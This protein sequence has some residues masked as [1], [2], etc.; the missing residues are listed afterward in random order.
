MIPEKP[1]VVKWKRPQKPPPRIRLIGRVTV[2]GIILTSLPSVH[3]IE[4]NSPFVSL[5]CDEWKSTSEI[6]AFAGSQ[7]EWDDIHWTF[8][9]R[10]EQIF[11]VVVSSGSVLSNKIIG[12]ELSISTIYLSI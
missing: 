5:E 2:L 6:N 9:V 7:A 8:R 1:P 12:N 4:K 11:K 3:L 10:N